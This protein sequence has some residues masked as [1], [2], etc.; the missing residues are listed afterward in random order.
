MKFLKPLHIIIILAFTLLFAYD[1]FPIFPVA[2]TAPKSILIALIFGLYLFS[3]LFK[4]YRNTNNKEILKWQIF[5]TVY[6]LFLIG[7]FTI[8]GGKST[9]GISFN[10]GFLWIVFCISLFDMYSQWKKVKQSET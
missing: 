4:R 5:S 8:M 3:F 2:Y 10:N 9:S 6:I 1:Y 7:L